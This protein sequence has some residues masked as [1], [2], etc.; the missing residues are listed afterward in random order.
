MKLEYNDPRGFW[1]KD[2]LVRIGELQ[3]IAVLVG[4][5]DPG[6]LGGLFG[7][8]E[9][10]ILAVYAGKDSAV[11]RDEPEEEPLP[12]VC[13]SEEE[14]TS[15][16]VSSWDV[17]FTYLGL[18]EC[19]NPLVLGDYDNHTVAVIE[20]RSGTLT[21][22]AGGGDVAYPVDGLLATDIRLHHP[23]RALVVPGRGLHILDGD[24]S[25][26][27][28]IDHST[29]R[30][31]TVIG[32]TV[33]DV[34]YI[35]HE[36]V[37]FMEAGP[38]GRLIVVLREQFRQEPGNVPRAER[39]A[40]YQPATDKFRLIDLVAEKSVGSYFEDES[41]IYFDDVRDLAV[42][43]EGNIFVVD[44]CR[45]WR[46]D[47]GTNELTLVWAMVAS[48]WV[49]LDGKPVPF[50]GPIRREFLTYV[51][52]VGEDATSTYLC[53]AGIAADEPGH[54]LV[55]SQARVFRVDT[56]SGKVTGVLG[57]ENLDI[58]DA[59]TQPGKYSGLHLLHYGPDGRLNLYLTSRTGKGLLLAV[60][61]GTTSLSPQST[62]AEPGV[63]PDFELRL[64]GTANQQG[65]GT[66]R[67][68]ETEGPVLV[69]T[70]RLDGFSRD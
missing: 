45:V 58:G 40:K 5:S 14:P 62:T 65:G 27:L 24:N 31:Q 68:S 10:E 47:S 43:H 30:A 70:W 9:Q 25:R 16:P 59:Q 36:D 6:F 8:H 3:A 4:D 44:N 55:S 48:E 12:R 64:F 32:E 15:E 26:V 21:T 67:L 38:D 56:T 7:E 34:E 20:P 42:D 53:A 1:G 51:S 35:H 66:W 28:Y 52:P 46:V 11:V 41:D 2:G 23:T 69:L 37:N 29:R 18:D 22:I 61:S 50:I 60:D 54:V 63:A 33:P 39:L 13:F 57:A 17:E 19:G 49:L